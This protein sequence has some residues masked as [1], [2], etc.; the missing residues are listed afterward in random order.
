[1]SGVIRDIEVLHPVLQN[2]VERIKKG[3]IE[4]HSAPFRLFETGRTPSRQES[5]YKKGKVL[6]LDSQQFFDVEADPPQYATGFNYVYFDGDGWS[7][8]VR[9][10]K[11]KAWY[12]LFGELVLDICPEVRWGGYD[13]KGVDYTYF[14]LIGTPTLHEK[15]E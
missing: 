5:L 2:C 8:N 14:E 1:M 7:W 11:I 6:S 13:R 15:G 10:A 12:M 3:V 9:D 4:R